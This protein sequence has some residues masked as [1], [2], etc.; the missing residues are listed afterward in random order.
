MS[1]FSFAYLLLLA[2][3]G[4]FAEDGAAKEEIDPESQI[5][6]A[7][8]CAL[9]AEKRR[10]E[11]VTH[12]AGCRLRY[13]KSKKTKVIAKSVRGVDVCQDVLTKTQKTLEEASYKCK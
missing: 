9:G 7:V 13:T 3:P 2:A 4:A 12:N 8:D 5:V 10:L 1:W 6:Q 11:V